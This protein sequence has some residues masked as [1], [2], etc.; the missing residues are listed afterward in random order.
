MALDTNF[1]VNP[2]YDDFEEDKKYLRLL[3]KPGSAVQARELTQIQSL[4]QNQIERFGNHVFKNGSL[5]TG[6]QS[7]LQN[8]TYLKLDSSYNNDD[9][10]INNFEN[11]TIFSLDETKRAEV[12]KVYD[13]DLGTGDPKTL[14][15]KQI[16]GEDFIP[17]ETIKTSEDSP[18]FANI[19]SSG[20]GTGQIFSV[21]EGVFYY[22]GFFI[23]NDAQT[24]ATSKY[25][26]LEANARIGFEIT[27]SILTNNQDTSL[28]DP[29]QNA[30]NYQAPGSD[31]YKISLLLSPRSLDSTDDSQFIEI[32]RVERGFLT[33]QNKYPLYAV[34]EDT[35]ARRTF[36]ES[37]N[38]TVRPFI[39]SLESNSS[40]TAQT[41]I[42]LS[43]GKA[44]LF[45]YEFETNGPT[46]IL[47]DK[48]RTTTDVSNKR[49]SSDY[50]NF[51]FVTNQ[52]G[53]FPI[54]NL[55][56]IDL[57]C[58]P[59][60]SINTT[61]TGTISNTK[62]GTSR[63]KSFIFDSA[64]NT[65]NGYTYTYKTFLFDTD[66]GSIT[67]NVNGSLSNTTHVALSGTNYSKVD[68]AY[69]GAKFRITSGLGSD[70]TFRDVI[71]YNGANQT[72]VL[73][74]SLPSVPN[75]E[76]LFSIDFEFNDV[77]S[78]T[79]FSGT[80]I[81][82]G[83]DISN[84]SKD[85][86]TPYQDTIF[87]DSTLEP[88][89]FILGEQ[90]IS[91]NTIS[92]MSFTY[93]RLYNNQSFSASLSP[94]LTVGT[95]EDISSA[96]STSAKAEK[97]QLVVTSQG[98]S[99]YEVGQIIP[100]EKYSIDVGTNRITVVNGNN[101]IANIVA[102]IDVSAVS[103]KSKIFL[104]GN[105]TIQTTGGEN[106]FNDN[107]VISFISSG[108]CHISANTISKIPG[109]FQSL[110]VTDVNQIISVLDFNGNSISEANVA[111]ATNITNK[112]T[113]DNGQRDSYYDHSGIVL[114]SGAVAG[115]GPLVVIYDRFTS[116]GSGFFTVDSYSTID[117]S[118]IPIYSSTK[119]EQQYVLRDCIDFRPV[120]VDSTTGSLNTVSFD[121]D[122][123]TTGP[124]IPENGSDIILDY[125]FFLA[126]IDKLVLDKTSKFSIIKGVASI[127]PEPPND[128]ETGMTLYVLNYP[129]YVTDEKT[130]EIRQ[131]NHKR[132]TMK[133][134]ASIEKRVENLEYYTSLTLLEQDTASKQDLS[135]LDSQNIPRFKNGIIVDAFKG[136]S[137][138]DVTRSDYKA[139]VDP[140]NQE[141]RPSFDIS[142]HALKYD[143]ANSS[144]VVQTGSLLTTTYSPE[145]LIDQPKTSRAINVNPFN[146]INFL[147][148]IKLSPQSDI[149]VDTVSQPSVLVNIGGDRDAWQWLTE[150]AFE[151]EWN[152]WNTV[153]TGVDVTTRTRTQGWLTFE[154]TT[155]TT[156]NNQ[157]RTG[158][159]TQI[160]PETIT[161]S[162]GNRILDVS[163]IPFMRSIN[164]LYI[165][166]D[167]KPNTILFPF[168][169]NSS[170]EPFVGNRVNKF[171]LKNNNLN[172]NLNLSNPE[173]VSIRNKD[174]NT[175]NGE[176]LVV[177]TSNNI[178]YVTNV[179]ANT[180]FG[181]IANLEIVGSQTGLRYDAVSY[182]H[183]GAQ[184]QASTANTVTFRIDAFAS[185]NQSSF[186]NSI[187]FIT[188]GPGAGQTRNIV[189]YNT[190][191]RVATVDSNWTTLPV[192]QQ[193]FYAVGRA[194]TD[195]SG[196]VVGI[197]TI[198]P[199]RFRIGEKLFRLTDTASGDIPSSTTNG[200]CSF[201]AQ[202]L[203]QNQQETI[204]STIAP[205]IQRVS[206]NDDRVITNSTTTSRVIADN[207]PRPVV[208]WSDPLAETFL[209]SP[210]QYP[211]GLFLSKVRLCFKS[212]DTTVP[213][214]LQVRPTLNGYPSSSIVYP[215]S[216]VSLTP[217]KVKVSNTPNMN[218]AN[219]YTEFVF[220]NPVY[221][222]PGEHSFV[223]LANSNKYEA[224]VAEIGKL[225]IVTNRQISEQPYG[226]SLFLSQ[227][228]S[229]W[230]ADQNS[231]MM[232]QIYK[233]N[234]TDDSASVRF[235]VDYPIS[236]TKYDMIQLLTA[237]VAMTNTS[238]G[239]QFN[240]ELATGGFAGLKQIIP[241]RNYELS[242]INET[243]VLSPTSGNSTFVL[244]G[245]MTTLS[246][247]VSP[248]ID[249]SRIGLIVV[250][251]RI[252]NLELSNND[253]VISNTGSGYANSSD[254]TVT[255]SGGGG[256]GATAVA[257][258]VSN[259]ISAIYITSGGSG[260]TSSPNIT[261]TP[262]SGGGGNVVV[263]Y[264]GETSS[265][266]GNATARYMTRR[267]TLADGFDSGDLRVYLNANK[268]PGTNIYV[269][270]KI[271]SSSDPDLFVNKRWQLMTQITNSNYNSSNDVD[272]RE[273]TF[274]PGSNG[275]P[276]N[277]VSYNTEN[278]IYTTFRSFAIKI[279]MASERD[280][281]VPKIKDLRVIAIPAG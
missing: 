189:S 92:D 70:I 61:S 274:A 84:R 75:N 278:T 281:L 51:V 192:P 148:K 221:I 121:V 109:E 103:K 112:Y 28:L 31:R 205:T 162:I 151:Y 168:F 133:D 237:E 138:A 69:T 114:K 174:T 223:L 276:S 127:N 39:I 80:N 154:D 167:F 41:N 227:N 244:Q 215:F 101:M 59:I 270:Y 245:S 268:R 132:Y 190:T 77:E 181:N 26:I 136:H 118:N 46:K 229:T 226:G 33:Q 241:F 47:I 158:I 255:I 64:S 191:T 100:A 146:V 180:P 203:L 19:A 97:Y 220:S 49:I 243:R 256:S 249:V 213:V 52:R 199:T 188:D 123:T 179:T 40:N 137:V 57:H 117:Y 115:V 7:F 142:V 126:R 25:S 10:L 1:N 155:R 195:A 172:F 248:M 9:I 119:N 275:S 99:P 8:A 94:S 134:I 184:V 56:T 178:V 269:Y 29:A 74:G 264:I 261:V 129:P 105:T 200:D 23:Q 271:L 73:S 224:Y 225:D 259:T 250:K 247:S 234:F 131:V 193:S 50:G 108:Q 71:D 45:G 266:G 14:M 135:I 37:G 5:V 98:T 207:T 201:Y 185:V 173:V 85:F 239:Y 160:V 260:Y 253:I 149:W 246:S 236:N 38:Y 27:E 58:V 43:P 110:H 228:G 76:S 6:G 30:S 21:N 267:V 3:F 175:S 60:N 116:S 182:E 277:Q 232:F 257:N 124:K 176:G 230:T 95:G 171:I 91:Q 24:I 18:S 13:T 125:S 202:G 170:V 242:G 139:A 177:H 144:N 186:V 164:V 67:G 219:T 17:G 214:T 233:N 206:V 153:W 240:S 147:G 90:F 209:V 122:S 53:T 254:V 68:G 166:T 96:V 16:F 217:D 161:Q 86:A 218:D 140:I 81:V 262:G 238:I 35:L 102:T 235:L 79:N 42:S 156:N 194:K 88:L 143:A 165:G 183:N 159:L 198:P 62:I 157:T 4:M 231:D 204:I 2:Y 208:R 251:N 104:S 272:Y 44:Y 83:A 15:I 211:E 113:L 32:A 106:V 279:V 152:S 72:I 89:I 252:N 66:I 222:Q 111:L 187:I 212:K 34:L 65:S 20:V 130:I 128:S 273:L 141:L 216:T 22:D 11:F 196:S 263:N 54:N 107:S 36:D 150:N 258:V 280:N 48:P 78:L 145:L 197:F 120:R 12:I 82:V 55:Q 93:K 265:S 163:I 169:D 63:V 87:S 210:E